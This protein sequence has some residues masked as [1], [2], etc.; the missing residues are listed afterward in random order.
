MSANATQPRGIRASIRRV[1]AHA[2]SVSELQKELAALELKQKASS[3]GAG[4]AL[5]VAA[6]IMALYAVG[7]GLAT[8]AVALAIVLDLWLALLIVFAALVLLTVILGLVAKTMV[9]KGTPLAPEQA[10]E[11]ARLTKQALR[12]GHG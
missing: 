11:E 5:G 10:I 9:Q 12:S 1:V 7:F 3:L 6:G 4:A 8:A 2:R